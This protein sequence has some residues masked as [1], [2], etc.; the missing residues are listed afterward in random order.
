M[1]VKV[2]R[3]STVL[4]NCQ[5]ITT[6]SSRRENN[7]IYG[8]GLPFPK[9]IGRISERSLRCRFGQCCGGDVLIASLSRDS[10]DRIS[11]R[12]FETAVDPVEQRMTWLAG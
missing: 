3:S 5:N 11:Q 6:R 4:G 9:Y 8:S 1:F 12:L 10:K 7:G 2:M